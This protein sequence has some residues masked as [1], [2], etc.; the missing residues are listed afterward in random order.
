[1]RALFVSNL[2]P[3]DYL[4]GYEILCAQ[5]REELLKRG[6]EISVLTSAPAGAALDPASEPGVHRDLRLIRDFQRPYG[7]ERGPKILTTRAN[8]RVASEFLARERPEIVFVWSQ[9]RLSLGP[10]RAAHDANIPVAYTMNDMHP[11]SY[12]AGGFGLSPRRLARYALENLLFPDTCM[13]SLDLRHATCISRS[14][15][16]RLVVAGLPLASARVI[17]QGIPL[18]RFPPK[19]A[20]GSLGDPL[21]LLFVGQLHAYKGVHT[22]LEAFA[23][24][25]ARATRELQLTIVGEGPQDYVKRLHALADEAPG[26]VSFSAKVPYD[27]L[28]GVYRAHDAFVFPSTSVEAFGLTFLEAMASGL[29]LIATK[30]GGHA[31]VLDDGE[32]ALLVGQGDVR[33]LTE[34]LL[35]LDGDPDL[36]LRLARKGRRF[37][38]ERFTLDRYVAE[39]EA[40]LEE[41]KRQGA[42]VG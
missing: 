10:A 25:A 19:Q 6:H 17:Y 42:G 28:P 11:A 3:P 20:P 30:V 29:P 38:E 22:L 9:L 14:L 39:L 15:K 8:Y 35:R 16:E 21:R 24:A 2:Y 18:E 33:A 26:R 37:V 5:I 12:V 36:C 40:F 34:A 31:E 32:T 41:V 4:G 13:Q 7:N 27:E 1:M 23:R